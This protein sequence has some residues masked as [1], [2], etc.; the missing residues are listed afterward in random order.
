[1]MLC[2]ISLCVLMCSCVASAQPS[3][4][5][6]TSPST[7]RLR[8]HEHRRLTTP[9]TTEETAAML[10]RIGRVKCTDETSSIVRKIFTTNELL[11]DTC[12]NHSGYALFPFKGRW[13]EREQTSRI[14]ASPAC[15]DLLSGIVLA[16]LPECTVEETDVFSP[17]SL[18][19]SL[20]R[21]RVDLANNRPAP[22]WHQFEQLYELNMLLNLLIS[23]A[24]REAIAKP[25]VNPLQVRAMMNPVEINPDVVLSDSYRV[26]VR[27]EDGTSP[28]SGPPAADDAG[29]ERSLDGSTTPKDGDEA[30]ALLEMPP[31]LSLA[32][33]YIAVMWVLV[34]AVYFWLMNHRDPSAMAYVNKR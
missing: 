24:E 13:P 25:R 30:S 1:M 12:S 26:Y 27:A 5:N 9:Y 8:L 7:T 18:A 11:L 31:D 2:G 19:E 16:K 29:N 23:D 14:C 32:Y 17:R 10:K 20:F 15:M 4:A 21:I 28:A 33:V 22:Q 3:L 34:N 6:T